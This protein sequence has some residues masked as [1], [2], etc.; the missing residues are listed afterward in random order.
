MSDPLDAL[1][2]PGTPIAP[3]PGFAA[4]LR[5]R[6]ATALTEGIDEGGAMASPDTDLDAAVPAVG[7][8]PRI[9][10]YLAVADA[11]RAVQWYVDVFDARPGEVVEMPDGRLGHAEVVIGDSQLMMADE[12]PEMNLLGPVARGG[13]SVSLVLDVADLDASFRRA[14]AAGAVVER[15]PGETPYGFRAAAVVDPFGHRWMLEAPS[16]PSPASDTSGSPSS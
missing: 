8:R 10:A 1:R 13:P 12:F 11:R 7:S 16:G 5:R 6:V 9:S 3:D 14:V 4:E 2:L 15:E